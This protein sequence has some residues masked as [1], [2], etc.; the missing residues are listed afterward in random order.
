MDPLLVELGPDD[1]LFA[2][3]CEVW[4]AAGLA[5]RPDEAPRSAAEHAALGRE[6]LADGGS[7]TGTHRAAVVDGAVAGALRLILPLRDNVTVAVLD[8]AVHP[9]HRRRGIGSALLAE[10]LALAAAHR[11]TDVIA[12]VYEPVP[13]NPGRAFA[14]R[15]GWTCDLLESRRDLHLPV[16]EQRLEALEA[17]AVSVGAGYDVVTW[18]DRRRSPA[19]ARCCPR[20][21]SATAGWWATPTSRSRSRSRSGP[22]S[23]A[24]WSCASTGVTGS[25]RG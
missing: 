9:R 12:D 1:P 7:R 14:L 21:R 24:R 22:S 16:D 17:D 3:W 23:P 15:H 4:A 11:R 10:A 5:D 6:L 2:G 8:L 18:R 25:A 20:V 13:D 19:A